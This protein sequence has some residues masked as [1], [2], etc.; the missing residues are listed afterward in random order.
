MPRCRYIG[1]VNS[2]HFKDARFNNAHNTGEFQM[3]PFLVA[4]KA[5]SKF[6]RY[7]S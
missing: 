3:P 1:S 5:A 2:L 6:N 7:N 4:T